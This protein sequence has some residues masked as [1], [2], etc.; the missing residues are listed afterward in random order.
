MK[1]YFFLTLFLLAAFLLAAC[2]T[3]QTT[4]VTRE[5]ITNATVSVTATPEPTEESEFLGGGGQYIAFTMESDDS[6]FGVFLIDPVTKERIALTTV[7]IDASPRYAAGHLRWSPDG[8]KIAFTAEDGDNKNIYITDWKT[9]ESSSLL[10]N[11]T[12]ITAFDWSPA[13]NQ[14]AFL[15]TPLTPPTASEGSLFLADLDSNLTE[16]ATRDDFRV[17]IAPIVDW[18]TDD[19]ILV[20]AHVWPEQ[21]LALRT[22]QLFLVNTANGELNQNF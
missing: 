2:Q 19:Q 15:A 9:E 20:S 13:G 18:V 12:N 10:A 4:V 6:H 17:V 3:P 5:I 14:I 11:P 16:L 1:R 7:E 22:V 8:S 21:T